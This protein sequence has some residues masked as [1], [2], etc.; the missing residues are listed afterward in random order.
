M[1]RC[2]NTGCE[3]QAAE[4]WHDYCQR[5]LGGV[6]LA[7][8]RP[9]EGGPVSESPLR[10]AM[11]EAAGF[12]ER[13]WDDEPSVIVG[14]M[15]GILEEALETN[16]LDRPTEGGVMLT[17]TQVTALARWAQAADEVGKSGWG[18]RFDAAM[19]VAKEVTRA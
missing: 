17:P 6:V 10:V 2:R 16:P 15:A 18:P 19:K 9:N 11:K 4:D 5:C 8:D 14:I 1:P 13:P 3:N 7:P 12:A